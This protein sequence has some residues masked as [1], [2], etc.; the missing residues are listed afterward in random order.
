LVLVLAVGLGGLAESSRRPADGFRPQNPRPQNGSRPQRDADDRLLQQLAIAD[1]QWWPRAEPLPGG[2]TRYVY[3]RRPGDPELTLGQIK[4]LMRQ[5]PTFAYERQR[6]AELRQ[7]LL[8]LGVR[9]ELSQPQKPGAA[10][11]WDPAARTVR[12][13]PAVVAKGSAEFARVLNH[14]AIHVAQSC[15]G[16]GIGALPQP[17]GLP[18][19]LPA[20]L[21]SVLQDSTYA[22]ASTRERELER[23]A[24]AHQ[25]R[26]DLGLTLLSLHC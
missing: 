14:E 26:L 10:A 24:Y 7:A 20:H 9:L 16:G 15:R 23:E 5:P 22:R 18:R 1:R 12:L 19:Q 17:L 8:A 6:I 4:E 25:D 2:G 21:Q 13:K 3:R 11:E